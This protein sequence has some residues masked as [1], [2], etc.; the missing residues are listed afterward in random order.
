MNKKLRLI[1]G[2]F[3]V[4]LM[5]IFTKVIVDKKQQITKQ[6]NITKLR[7]KHKNYLETSPYKETKRLSK[8][9]RKAL[10]LPP[11]AYNEQLWDRTLDPNLGYPNTRGA[12]AIQHDLIEAR[13]SQVTQF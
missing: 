9:E 5:A 11:N 10:G 8:E 3:T 1:V 4:L 6:D 2:L 7:E 12:L 13:R